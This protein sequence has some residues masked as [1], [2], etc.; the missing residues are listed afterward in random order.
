MEAEMAAE[1]AA[2]VQVP[3]KQTEPFWGSGATRAYKRLNW[4]AETRCWAQRSHGRGLCQSRAIFAN[5]RCAVHGGLSTGP[6]TPE[7]KARAL[8]ALR[9]INA[10]RAPR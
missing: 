10:S 8:A 9:A 4:R 5:G 7:G 6:R 1:M 3:E 2:E